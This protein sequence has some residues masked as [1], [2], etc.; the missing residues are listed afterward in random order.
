[1]NV[2]SSR[3]IECN[4]ALHTVFRHLKPQNM[5][6]QACSIPLF[7]STARQVPFMP[8]SRA[9]TSLAVRRFVKTRPPVVE[10]SITDDQETVEGQVSASIRRWKIE[11]A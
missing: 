1:M 7:L 2:V 6:G 5:I 4:T 3:Q 8:L 9:Y 10:V 11:A